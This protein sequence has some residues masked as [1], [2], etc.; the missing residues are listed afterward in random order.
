VRGPGAAGLSAAARGGAVPLAAVRSGGAA[1]P[2]AL[3]AAG[4]ALFCLGHPVYGVW[5]LALAALAPLWAALEGR[6]TAAR[7]A[8]LGLVF[9]AVAYVAGFAWL[10]RLVDVFLGGDRTLGAALFAAHGALFA[11]A[12]GLYALAY[13]ALRARGRGVALAGIAPL[14][15]IEWAYPALFPVR[16]GDAL[17]GSNAWVQAAD[18]GGALG[19]TAYVALANAALYEVWRWI[20]GARAL[21]AGLVAAAGL[22]IVGGAVYGE[23]RARS[24]GAAIAAA[25][26]LRVGLVQ[27][28]LDPL[29]KRAAPEPVL[30]RHRAATRAL[31]GAGALDLVV[32]PETVQARGLL[33]P[34]P[35]SGELVRGDLRVPI[36]FGGVSIEPSLN[37]R[38][39]YNSA[40]L[41]GADGAI[42]TAYDKRRLVPFAEFL[43]VPSLLAPL[44]GRFAHAQRF[45]A[46]TSDAPLA[47]G[48][49]RVAAP[50]C[51]ETASAAAVRALVRAGDAHLVVSLANDGWFGDSREPE[52]QHRLAQ[53]RA[54]EMRRAVVRATNTGVS[55]VIDPL[56]RVAERTELGRETALRA[57]VPLLTVATPY[58]R[59]GDWPGPLAAVLAAVALR[60]R[61]A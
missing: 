57:E 49:W 16:L 30:E 37:G 17:A 22:A 32:W 40:L 1:L 39:A 11:G 24:V 29:T 6:P 33:R 56:G 43:P 59:L 47:L 14:V 42:R 44:A 55:A 36:L 25:P 8:A 4:G 7:A 19:L 18:L 45:A 2:L 20:R 5:P 52:L 31:L 46:G 48:P 9:G 53:L 3:A 38:A 12:Y 54:V 27:A 51:S 10:L 34:L 61:G 26:R 35:V 50:I 28:N 60:R 23:V 58:A 21:P 13:R 15:A 41:I